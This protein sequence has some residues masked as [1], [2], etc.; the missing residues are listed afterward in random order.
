MT[1]TMSVMCRI[2]CASEPH[3]MTYVNNWVTGEASHFSPARLASFSVG[4]LRQL[5][6]KPRGGKPRMQ[7]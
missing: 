3:G 5:V 4:I 1:G 7:N 2:N 6:S